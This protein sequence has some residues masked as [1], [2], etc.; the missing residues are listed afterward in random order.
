MTRLASCLTALALLSACV[1]T[2][3]ACGGGLVRD[4]VDAC[5]PEPGE[6]AG[7]GDAGDAGEP[8]DAFVPAD[9]GPCE[10]ACTGGEVCAEVEAGTFECVDCVGDGDCGGRYCSAFTCVDCVEHAHCTE[11]EAAQCVSGSCVPCAAPAHCAGTTAGICDTT[12]TPATCV[13]CTLSDSD[14][15]GTGS[16]CDLFTNACV[17]IALGARGTCMPCSNDLQCAADHRCIR[18][19]YPTGTPRATGHCLRREATGCANPYRVIFSRASV[20]GA[21]AESY[22]GI[23]ESRTTCEAVLALLGD[24]DCTGD[25]MCVIGGSEVPV[26]GAICERVAGTEGKCT[27]ACAGTA[28][29][30]PSGISCAGTPQMYCGG[31]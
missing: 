1:E 16:T 21:A 28:A 14:A 2:T 11:P 27:Y 18:M 8:E 26:P 4:E 30:C 3:P 13:E 29:H 10:P 15:C 25:G 5:V 12:R 6:D 19:E 24:A 23:D 22:C 17:E 9:A 20:S 7:R 31:T